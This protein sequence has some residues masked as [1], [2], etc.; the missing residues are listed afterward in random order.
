M[1]EEDSAID[2]EVIEEETAEEA[3]PNEVILPEGDSA[4]V[5]TETDPEAAEILVPETETQE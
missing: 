3:D 1:V 4:D 5:E 2:T